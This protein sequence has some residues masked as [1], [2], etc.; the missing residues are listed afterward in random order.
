MPSFHPRSGED[1]YKSHESMN[2]EFHWYWGDIW[3]HFKPHGCIGA[4][5]HR[6]APGETL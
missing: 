1:I 6:P 2:G 4:P 5:L 3:G